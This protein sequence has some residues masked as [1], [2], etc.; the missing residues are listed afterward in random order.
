MTILSH[1][2]VTALLLAQ[3]QVVARRQLLEVGITD[4]Q[5]A[6]AIRPEGR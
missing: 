2:A 3:C 5:I 6:W 1:P 4:R